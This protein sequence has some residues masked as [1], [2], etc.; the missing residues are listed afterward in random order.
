MC[1]CDTQVALHDVEEATVQAFDQILN[2]PLM[3][4]GLDSRQALLDFVDLLALAHPSDRQS[5][6]LHA[7]CSKTDDC[8]HP[9]SNKVGCLL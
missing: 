6:I 4:D 7:G 2:N 3:L 5:S 1:D 9:R 8:D